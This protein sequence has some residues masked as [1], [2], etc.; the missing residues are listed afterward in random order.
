MPSP[1]S[2]F[3]PKI[4]LQ[5][6]KE[7]TA[8][9]P[10][11]GNIEWEISQ[12]IFCPPL[13]GQRTQ[14]GAQTQPS[15]CEEHCFSNEGRHCVRWPRA[16]RRSRGAVPAHRIPRER[17]CAKDH[18]DLHVPW[19]TDQLQLRMRPALCPSLRK[20]WK[21]GHRQANARATTRRRIRDFVHQF[22]TPAAAAAPIQSVR[23]TT[24]VTIARSVWALSV[25]AIQRR[26]AEGQRRVL[27]ERV[28]Q[29][30]DVVPTWHQV[31]E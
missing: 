28:L 14:S 1:L 15:A 22:A 23:P 30:E 27:H 18:E 13:S 6:L 25:P 29:Q 2:R 19:K 11:S 26:Q 3:P 24:A 7:N 17:Q 4:Q 31:R 8:A 16:D 20:L 9:D 12:S 5:K 10:P 21:H